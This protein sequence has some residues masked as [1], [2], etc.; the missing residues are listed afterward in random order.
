MIRNALLIAMVC[1]FVGG[2]SSLMLKERERALDE[3]FEKGKINK[4]QY[5]SSKSELQY[6]K[7]F[8]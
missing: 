7:K 1:F 5:L 8:K 4:V 2:C 3:A 6:D